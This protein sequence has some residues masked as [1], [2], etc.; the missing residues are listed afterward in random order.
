MARKY[1]R[2]KLGRFAV[3]GGNTRA[4]SAAPAGSAKD[5]ALAE[6]AAK[7]RQIKNEMQPK[8]KAASSRAQDLSQQAGR[9]DKALQ[10]QKQVVKQNPTKANKDRLK[11]IQSESRM[12]N[13]AAKQAEKKANALSSKLKNRL[14]RIGRRNIFGF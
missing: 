10:K 13:K 1:K 12:A 2:D 5:K 6:K 9:L 7:T 14:G 3:K 4:T 8:I 11:N